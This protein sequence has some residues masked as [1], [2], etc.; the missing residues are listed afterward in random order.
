MQI[1]TDLYARLSENGFRRSGPYIYTPMCRSCNSCVS[2]RIP[3]DRFLPSRSQKRCLRANNDL[4]VTR[5][6]NIDLDEHYVVYADYIN[7]RHSDG[8]MYPPTKKQF[9]DFL[10]KVWDGTQ[11]IEFRLD[12]RL[13]GCAIIDLLPDA[14]SAIYTYFDPIE[15]RR[16]LG[17]FAVLYQIAMAKEL[18]LT[19]VYLGY[20]IADSKKMSYKMQYRPIE[21]LQ[22]NTWNLSK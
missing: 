16:G 5:L 21:L 18:A 19:H 13:I 11:F 15:K 4:N 6:P 17:N 8:D 22:E 10:G 20:W 3:V 14:I 12:K 2:A 1:T 9:E 7:Q